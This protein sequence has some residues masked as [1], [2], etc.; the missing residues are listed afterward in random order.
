MRAFIAGG[1]LLSITALLFL[2]LLSDAPQRQ[3]HEGIPNAPTAPSGPPHAAP[4][5]TTPLQ[6]CSPSAPFPEP[7][8]TQTPGFPSVDLEHPSLWRVY[9]YPAPPGFVPPAVA[10]RSLPLVQRVGCV[11]GRWVPVMNKTHALEKV[12]P[13]AEWVGS[14]EV[15]HKRLVRNGTYHEGLSLEDR[16]EVQQCLAGKTVVIAGN[17]LARAWIFEMFRFFNG[18]KARLRTHQKKQCGYSCGMFLPGPVHVVYVQALRMWLP[19]RSV[20]NKS[21]EHS[22]KVAT[23]TPFG[24]VPDVFIIGTGHQDVFEPGVTQKQLEEDAEHMVCYLERLVARGVK[25]FFRTAVPFRKH[26]H[27]GF[28]GDQTNIDTMNV[29]LRAINAFVRRRLQRGGV[30]LLDEE[31]LADIALKDGTA[32]SVYEDHVHAPSIA[33]AML[34]Y[35]LA[36]LCP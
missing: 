26:Y 23:G 16:V 34:Q 21:G 8:L 28:F 11:V 1:A 18:G 4:A 24:V 27:I 33:A 2:P 22:L 14:C 20:F 31:A 19:S 29:K 3:T 13:E 9:T 6:E 10:N 17:S 7:E 32:G 35:T 25:V 15:P 30:V 5:L 36:A 12:I